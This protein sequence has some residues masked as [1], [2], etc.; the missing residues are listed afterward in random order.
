MALEVNKIAL[1][2]GGSS[3]IG[4]EFARQLAN[5]GKNILIVSNQAEEL[6]KATAIIH[7]EAPTISIFALFQ[8]LRAENSA[9]ILYCYCKDNNLEVN[10]LI[11][12]AGI[13]S[14]KEVLDLSED[15]LNFFIDLHIRSV[16]QLCHMFGADMKKRGRG[17]ILNMSSMSCWMPMPGIG[18][19]AATKAYIRVFSR[20]LYLELKEYGVTVTVACPGGIATNLFGLPKNLQH[21]GVRHGVLT[22]P[23]R[24][25]KGALKATYKG[26]KQYINGFINHLA[27]FFV[28][29]LPTRVRLIVKHKLLDK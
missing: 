25:V 1:I 10:L 6:E 17:R 9:K 7:K 20:S 5:K 19:Y 28:A 13:F 8:D 18:M 22:T 2:T 24:F 29:I 14:F 3:G 21:L 12:N 15:Q 23:Q 27:I 26:K 4:L 11:N 16:T